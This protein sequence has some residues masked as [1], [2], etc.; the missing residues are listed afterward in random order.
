MNAKRIENLR[1]R[2]AWY[3]RATNTDYRRAGDM[4]NECLN[5]IGELNTQLKRWTFP[6]APPAPPP[7]D[8][9]PCA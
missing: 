4:L 3:G 6:P 9:S 2:A 7:D 1:D 5:E 8:D